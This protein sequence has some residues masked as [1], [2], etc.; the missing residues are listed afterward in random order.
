MRRA[1]L[2]ITLALTGA[3]EAQLRKP[4]SPEGDWSFTT[5]A[6]R[7]DCALSGE[8]TVRRT[9]D[10]AF[11]CSFDAEWSCKSGPLR[12]VRTE[13][14]CA[15][16]QA[17]TEFMVKSKLDRVVSADPG[18]TLG[19]LRKAYAPDNFE[20]T[21]NSRG[22]EMDGLFRSYDSAP[23]KFRRKTQLIS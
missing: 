20:V 9:G 6:F 21:I 18:E 17:G 12:K 19:W 11:S 13:Q 3:A 22:D 14:S 1:A 16:T 15:A 8:M 2:L 5:A 7:A 23:V 10:N 4:P